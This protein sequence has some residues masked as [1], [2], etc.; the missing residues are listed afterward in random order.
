MKPKITETESRPVGSAKETKE[1]ITKKGSSK[2]VISENIK[3][4]MNAGVPQK[5]AVAIALSIARTEKAKH[6]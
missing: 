4:E 5:K 6:K 3:N 2:A 1:R